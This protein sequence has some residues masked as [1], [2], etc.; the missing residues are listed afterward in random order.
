MAEIKAIETRY[1][2]YR[3]RSRLEAKWAVYFDL[4][5][6]KYEYEPQGYVLPDGECYLPDFYLPDY[7]A[8]VEI[9]PESI[10]SESS[11][12]AKDKLATLCNEI[13]KFGLICFGDPVQNNIKL[14]GK[15]CLD[16]SHQLFGSFPNYEPIGW[17][18]VEFVID[19]EFLIDDDFLT[20]TTKTYRGAIIVVGAR[21]FKGG[22]SIMTPD[23]KQINKVVPFNT[24]Y[25]FGRFPRAEQAQAREARFEHGECG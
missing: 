5:Y 13:G 16:S 7:E 15:L 18:T 10:D 2:G 11:K 6:I 12:K 19:A 4:L 8:Y 1:H 22:F 20:I 25:G 9:K 23:G 3:F 24:L 14:W 17:N 21:Y